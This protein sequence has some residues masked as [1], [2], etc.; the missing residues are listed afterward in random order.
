MKALRIAVPGIEKQDGRVSAALVTGIG[1]TSQLVQSRLDLLARRALQQNGFGAGDLE[2]VSVRS[3]GTIEGFYSNGQSQELDQIAL[4]V[5]A[6]AGGLLRTGNSF[7]EESPNSG[8]A[9]LQIAGSGGAGTIFS[10]VLESSNV[11]IAEEFVQL[12]E[13]QR[14]FQAN[15]RVIRVSDELLIELVN[16]V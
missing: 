12:I 16:L 4:A 5:F 11:D 14:G 9:Q 1:L 7:F 2:S 3:D 10:G 13:A 15:A 6:N 8:L